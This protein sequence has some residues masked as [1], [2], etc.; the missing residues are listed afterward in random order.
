M[1]ANYLTMYKQ[2]I[3][4]TGHDYK[5]PF[6][7]LTS[8]SPSLR[9]TISSS[10]LPTPD[11]R[12]SYVWL[13]LRAEPVVITIP[14]I[15]PNRYYTAQLVDLTIPTTSPISVPART[16]TMAVDFPH[17]GLRLERRPAPRYQG[18]PSL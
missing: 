8:Q 14:K 12:Y 2:A 7:T 13:D 6:N 9:L 11:T 16:A 17:C 4:T 10:S 15:E 18:C 1:A 5:A 3:D